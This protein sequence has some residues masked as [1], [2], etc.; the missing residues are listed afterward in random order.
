MRARINKRVNVQEVVNALE[1]K[2]K[3]YSAA[4]DFIMKEE[5]ISYK[6]AKE[7]LQIRLRDKLIFKF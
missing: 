6:Q 1:H 5:G 7:L 4:I 3:Q 2:R